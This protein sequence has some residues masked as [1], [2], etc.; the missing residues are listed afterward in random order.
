MATPT[1]PHPLGY[2]GGPRG[3]DVEVQAVLADPLRAKILGEREVT[4]NHL[5]AAWGVLGGLDN[6]WDWKWSSGA[7]R[8]V[9]V[10]WVKV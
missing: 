5:G 4:R 2:L 6:S 7:K 1:L 10:D 8:G 9:C 3:E